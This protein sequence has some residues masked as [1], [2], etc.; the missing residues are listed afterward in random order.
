MQYTSFSFVFLFLPTV[1]LI[2]YL[3]VWIPPLRKYP[4]IKNIVLVAASIGFYCLAEPQYW[5]LIPSLMILNIGLIRLALGSNRLP[6]LRWLAVGI[7]LLF[8]I[9]C[10]YRSESLPLGISFFTFLAISFDID[11]RGIESK[12]EGLGSDKNLKGKT[13]KRTESEPR[14]EVRLAPGISNKA[15]F[16]DSALYLCFFASIVTGPITQFRNELPSLQHRKESL[17]SFLHGV[18]RFMIG[19][20]KKIAVAD[21][22]AWLVSDAYT[23]NTAGNSLTVSMAWLGAI[24]YSLQLYFDFSGYSDMAI[25]MGEMF[26]IHISENFHYPYAATS[27]N[28]F[29]HRWHISLTKWFTRYVYIPLGGN[30]VS[31]KRHF[32]NLLIVWILT[33]LWHGNGWTFLLWAM[34]HF[35]VQY[36]EK[37]LSEHH[38]GRLGKAVEDREPGK[39]SNRSSHSRKRAGQLGASILKRLYTLAVVIT[40]WSVFQSPD[41]GTAVSNIRAMY[42]FGNVRGGWSDPS[43][44][45]L[46]NGYKWPLILAVLFSFPIAERLVMTCRHTNSHAMKIVS[47]CATVAAVAAIFAACILSG[48]GMNYTA[49]L[50]AGF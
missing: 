20:I 35:A 38:E 48:L 44:L 21:I 8:L 4:V 1:L 24:A 9:W 34:I 6:W 45:S 3:T 25:G 2:Y 17:R 28:D 50:Y 29:W 46:M 7:N 33:G 27:I 42:H 13:L 36:I 19:Y 39:P 49:A 10:K 31:K 43:F 14:E 32:L 47:K 18:F 5:L 37:I 23:G 11:S 41:I 30:R 22:L 15:G 12:P 26:G 40:A 16:W